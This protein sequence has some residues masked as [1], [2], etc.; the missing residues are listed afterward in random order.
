MFG[1]GDGFGGGP[2]CSIA[3]SVC[4][5]TWPSTVSPLRRWKSR[6]AWSSAG[7]NAGP[8]VTPNDAQTPGAALLY[9]R[10]NACFSCATAGP[11]DP[12]WR[13]DGFGG[14]GPGGGFGTGP[15]PL[16][17]AASVAGPTW[18]SDVSPL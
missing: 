13:M 7:P 11:F 2:A 6:T 17:S 3:V 14:F 18:P 4:C 5:P 9:Q 15:E 16:L 8:G 1:C 12:C 10:C